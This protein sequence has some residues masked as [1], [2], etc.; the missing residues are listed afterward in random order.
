MG[1]RMRRREFIALFAGAAATW[2]RFARA[3]NAAIP[4]IGYLGSESPDLFASRL[5]AFRE[6]LR[7]T[8]YEEG[9][10]LAIEYRWAGG[11]N[12]R[13]PGLAADLV[14]RAVSVIAAPGSLASALA[15]Q[16]A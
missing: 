3:Q 13:L 10:N 8:G 14:G 4:A 5:R 7:E 1:D 15:A 16:A 11:H 9:R 2:P 12:D 6:G